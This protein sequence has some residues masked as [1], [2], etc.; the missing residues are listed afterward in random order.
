MKGTVLTAAAQAEITEILKKSVCHLTE[1]QVRIQDF[2]DVL[3]Q[4]SRVIKNTLQAS[5]LTIKTAANS[6][7]LVNPAVKQV[8]IISLLL[9]GYLHAN[10][11]T[12][13]DLRENAFKMKASFNFLLRA[14]EIYVT[15]STTY[16]TPTIR[17]FGEL[18]L[19][20]AGTEADIAQ[21]LVRDHR[22][23][24]LWPADI[25]QQPVVGGI[26][27]LGQR[28]RQQL[29]DRGVVSVALDQHR[30]RLV[31]QGQVLAPH[32]D[33]LVQPRPAPVA[34]VEQGDRDPQLGDGLLRQALAAA[35]LDGPAVIDRA[36]RNALLA[37]KGSGEAVDRRHEF[38]R[39]SGSAAGAGRGERHR[40]RHLWIGNAGGMG[41]RAGT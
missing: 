20:Q 10:K 1:L 3:Q 34:K 33:R 16:I 8:F 5:N 36:H 2:M 41:G 28:A 37:R 11:P 12:I 35:D 30:D 27:A 4:L 29:A 13:K 24:G 9:H 25:G 7:R 14:A 32:D 23:H 38:S 31:E 39:S 22:T 15:I 17:R 18:R 19:Y 40:Y 6:E 21:P 26:V